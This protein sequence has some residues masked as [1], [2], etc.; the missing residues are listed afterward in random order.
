MEFGKSFALATLIGLGVITSA[1]VQAAGSW[2]GA[3]SKYH[4]RSHS[5]K[6]TPGMQS[7]RSATK[8][9]PAQKVYRAGEGSATNNNLDLGNSGPN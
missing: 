2:D 7:G 8:N 1:Q 3:K 6:M 9:Y 4:Q 5:Q